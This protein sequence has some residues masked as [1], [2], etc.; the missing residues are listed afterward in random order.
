MKQIITF[1]VFILVMNTQS[2]AQEQVG[3]GQ[4]YE[5]LKEA[6]DDINAGNLTGNIELQITSNTTST[7]ASTLNQSGTGF[8][9]YSAIKI[10]PI[11]VGNYIVDEH[12]ILN[13]ADNVTIDGRIN[14]VGS[15]RSL[16]LS[17]KLVSDSAPLGSAVYMWNNANNNKFKFLQLKGGING[18]ILRIGTGSNRLIDNCIFEYIDRNTV[19]FGQIQGLNM[20]NDTIINN[21]FKNY[22]CWDYNFPT[23]NKSTAV[24]IN[25]GGG[26]CFVSGN[27]FYDEGFTLTNTFRSS[28]AAIR[29]GKY[30]IGLQPHKIIGNYIGGSEPNCGGVP[31]S[32]TSTGTGPLQFVGIELE[33]GNDST[34][35]ANNIITN[36][37]INGNKSN[38]DPIYSSDCI[39]GFVGILC[40]GGVYA[41]RNNVIGSSNSSNTI[42]NNL[43]S[44]SDTIV[45]IQVGTYFSDPNATPQMQHSIAV[46]KDNTIGGI[47]A[48]A[49]G[50]NNLCS[51][52][53]I[54]RLKSQGYTAI[55]NNII[56]SQLIVNSLN[57]T[58]THNVNQAVY[59]VLT[60]AGDSCLISNNIIS[61]LH[62]E[63]INN[64]GHAIG[65]I[66]LTSLNKTSIVDNIISNISTIG[67]LTQTSGVTAAGIIS[68]IINSN[69]SII[70]NKITGI[71][72]LSS[73]ALNLEASGISTVANV[74]ER[75]FITNISTL[76]TGTGSIASGISGTFTLCSN[77]I[78]TLGNTSRRVYG[79][80]TNGSNVYYNTIYIGGTPSNYESA[81]Y[82]NTA[83]GNNFSVM[84]N[85]LVNNKENLSGTS[86]RHFA[87]I[88]N[89]AFGSSYFN[90]NN[91][92][93]SNTSTGGA[94]ARANAI[95]YVDFASYL[96]AYSGIQNMN[97]TN[98][99]P[100]FN[101]ESGT[102]AVDYFPMASGMNATILPNVSVDFMGNTRALPLVMGALQSQTPLPVSFMNYDVVLKGTKSQISWITL[103]ETNTSHFD[104]EKSYDA[105]KWSVLNT[106]QASGNSSTPI[107]YETIDMEPGIGKTYYRIKTIDIDGQFSYSIVKDVYRHA[108]G[109]IT[110]YPNPANHTLYVSTDNIQLPATLQIVSLDGKILSQST[111]LN[112]NNTLNVAS[113]YAGMYLIKITD[114]DGVIHMNKL[115]KQ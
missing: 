5:N 28:P 1:L 24:I 30:G 87:V 20:F 93:V 88:Q 89:G 102:S 91:L 26:G 38:H 100:L 33:S 7:L 2:F 67:E 48:N 107:Q 71:H 112:T 53:G 19:K 115:E 68:N 9:S 56:G 39:Y 14:M 73:T 86:T 10:Y 21:E 62:N 4:T 41:I 46:I 35:V 104:I 12:I 37:Q 74:V 40:F 43:V 15:T 77:N 27:S 85:I 84:N 80:N 13:G 61:N 103:S 99:N 57:A 52:I 22:T 97:S 47:V 101:N 70:N 90:F 42:V 6:F 32:I 75:N 83:I 95:D 44:G 31:F 29:I 50:A 94:I 11:G 54:H 3:I 114:K 25:G 108:S 69:L 92:Y 66:R 110:M 23:Y 17:G 34:I 111:L 72:N 36:I 81:A 106:I 65:G 76:S 63:S 96:T 113:L 49:S 18:G 79:I 64:I 82:R 8:S 98:I 16:T 51:V 55:Q 105:K 59:G 78:I 60:S 109:S 58:S 45:G